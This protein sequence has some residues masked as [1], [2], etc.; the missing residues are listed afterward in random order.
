MPKT[1]GSHQLVLSIMFGVN[2]ILLGILIGFIVGFFFSFSMCFKSGCSSVIENLILWIP[3][4]S[5]LLTIP[6]TVRIT[7]K[8]RF[9]TRRTLLMVSTI[10]VWALVFRVFMFL[11]AGISDIDYGFIALAAASIL[12]LIHIILVRYALQRAKINPGI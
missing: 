6:L 7:R 2:M 12:L 1:S 4:A 9:N 10:L 3:L 5:L 8:A 11:G